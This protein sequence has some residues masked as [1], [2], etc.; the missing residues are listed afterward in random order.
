MKLLTRQE[1]LVL[2][3]VYAMNE[4]A[5]LTDIQ[6]RLINRTG[7]EWSISSVYVPLDRLA[8]DGYLSAT[9]GKPEARRGGKAKKYYELTETGIVKLKELRTLTESFWKEVEGLAFEG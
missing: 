8:E 5:V 7:K 3:T 2:L 6:D 9:I 4:P 1:E